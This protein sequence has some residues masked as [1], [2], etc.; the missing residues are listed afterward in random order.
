[1]EENA[2][3]QEVTQNPEYNKKPRLLARILSALVDMFLIFLCGFFVM[4]IVYDSIAAAITFGTLWAVIVYCESRFSYISL[5]SDGRIEITKE[6]IKS[7]LWQIIAATLVAF[8]VTIPLEL[9]LYESVIVEKV[10]DS[11]HNLGM[12]LQTLGEMFSENWLPMV[13]ICVLIIA[14]YQLPIFL[15]MASDE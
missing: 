2:V 7:N 8:L 15:R 4:Q 11:A 6:E 5:K 1:M 12:W 10:G 9:K 14:I 13:L 3:N